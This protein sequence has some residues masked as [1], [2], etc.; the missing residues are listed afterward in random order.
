MRGP[1]LTVDCVDFAPLSIFL[2]LRAHENAAR[3][4]VID[5]KIVVC[6]LN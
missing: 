3:G 6:Q 4:T 1:R 2:K 5:G